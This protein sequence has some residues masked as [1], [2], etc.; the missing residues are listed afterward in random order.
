MGLMGLGGCGARRAVSGVSLTRN[1]LQGTGE[2]WKTHSHHGNEVGN[3]SGHRVSLL[4]SIPAGESH[5]RKPHS[6]SGK[7]FS[8]LG[9]PLRPRSAEV[10]LQGGS[11]WI[12]P[13]SP[14]APEELLLRA[15]P[16]PLAA[17]S[18]GT[19]S[20]SAKSLVWAGSPRLFL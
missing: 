12:N 9:C 14:G 11:C 19:C 15:D 10:M 5:C 18:R 7:T 16:F 1:K 8:R 20:S 2:G 13:P 6:K 4:V 17:P 3:P